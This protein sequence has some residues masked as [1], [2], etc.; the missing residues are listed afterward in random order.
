M[1]ATQGSPHQTGQ[2][3]SLYSGVDNLYEAALIC[4]YNIINFMVKAFYKILEKICGY[5]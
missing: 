4:D 3:M 2:T 1:L 5:L